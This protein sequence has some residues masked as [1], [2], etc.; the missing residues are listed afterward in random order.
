MT[1]DE[2]QKKRPASCW[3]VIRHSTLIRHSTFVIRH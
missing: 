2:L 3:F 1:N